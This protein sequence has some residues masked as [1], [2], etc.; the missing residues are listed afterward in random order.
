MPAPLSD[1]LLSFRAGQLNRHVEIGFVGFD[2]E[3]L[4]GG[5]F[6]GFP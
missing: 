1:H 4:V 2:P 3:Q 5:A 6:D